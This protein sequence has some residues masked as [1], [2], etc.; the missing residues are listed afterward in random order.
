[1]SDYLLF[2]RDQ[3]NFL[4]EPGDET[5]K[6]YWYHKDWRDYVVDSALFYIRP[7]HHNP[8]SMPMFSET[9]IAEN[10]KIGWLYLGT[11]NTLLNTDYYSLK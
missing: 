6:T 11:V 3:E 1:M 5:Q 4:T 7:G 2:F 10:V 8:T 9:H